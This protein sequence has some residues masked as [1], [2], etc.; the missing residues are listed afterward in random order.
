M[1]ALRV[2]R[3]RRAKVYCI[4]GPFWAASYFQS[5]RLPKHPKGLRVTFP[6]KKCIPLTAQFS[7]GIY[8]LLVSDT[9]IC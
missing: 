1:I 7:N 4:C 5:A 3:S 9:V 8:G 6:G 2:A